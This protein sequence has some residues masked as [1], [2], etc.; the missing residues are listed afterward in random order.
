MMPD[1]RV[2]LSAGTTTLT[3]YRKMTAMKTFIADD[4]LSQRKSRKM[5]AATIRM[6]RT[7]VR[8]MC[9]KS[10]MASGITIMV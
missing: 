6:S 10:S 8:V 2:M 1:I 3:T 4:P 5:M 7:S 9:R